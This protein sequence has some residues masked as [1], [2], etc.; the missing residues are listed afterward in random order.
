[1][2]TVT[3]NRSSGRLRKLLQGCVSSKKHTAEPNLDPTDHPQS[4]HPGE[5]KEKAKATSCLPSFHNQMTSSSLRQ[6]ICYHFVFPQT[7]NMPLSPYPPMSISGIWMTEQALGRELLL[8][9][10]NCKLLTPVLI[11]LVSL[12]APSSHHLQ[13]LRLWLCN[14]APDPLLLPLHT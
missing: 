13:P 12:P 7:S 10:P 6:A 8:L 3:Q 2:T 11:C 9:P 1:M 5:K 4:Q 14:F